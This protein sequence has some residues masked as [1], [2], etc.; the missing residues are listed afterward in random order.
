M[1]HRLA[2]LLALIAFPV[3]ANVTVQVVGYTSSN[4]EMALAVAGDPSS[5]RL[6]AQS[7]AFDWCKPGGELATVAT[8]TTPDLG[9][10][11]NDGI[12][13]PFVTIL[14]PVV[15]ICDIDP[16]TSWPGVKATVNGV[17]KDLPVGTVVVFGPPPEPPIEVTY[18]AALNWTAPNTNTDG[19]PLTNLT[20]FRIYWGQTQGVYPQTMIVGPGVTGYVVEGLT[21]GTWYFVVTAFSPSGE[22]SFSNIA[23]KG[24]AGVPPP[25]PPPPP[26]TDPCVVTPLA[27]P[28]ALAWPTSRTGARTLRWTSSSQIVRL[29]Y[30]WPVG[31]NQSATWTD[32][33]GCTVTVAR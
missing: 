22:S 18:T 33:R 5:V 15:T 26:P 19:S 23:S 7:G 13:S 2:A 27:R 17:Q 24:V 20:G 25:P 6:D 11:N 21:P 12:Q 10:P 1:H 3:F 29:D 4:G 31:Q 14:G 28:T 9:V 8:P 30:S 32:D 16:N